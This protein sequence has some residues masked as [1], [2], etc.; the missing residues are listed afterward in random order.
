MEVVST[1]ARTMHN[2]GLAYWSPNINVLR[3]PRWGRPQETLGEEP[4]VVG[5]YVVNDV[6][7]LKYHPDSPSGRLRVASC[8][9]HYSAYDLDKWK[10]FI[11]FD[12]NAQVGN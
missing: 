10:N 1:E 3:D 2:T 6:R 7:G 4:F 11:R 5:R 12:Y 9:K 8:C